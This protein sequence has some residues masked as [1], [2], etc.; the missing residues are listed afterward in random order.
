MIRFR[1]RTDEPRPRRASFHEEFERL[2]K[3]ALALPLAAPLLLFGGW[4]LGQATTD[5]LALPE[6]ARPVRVSASP[7]VELEALRPFMERLRVDGARTVDYVTQYRDHVQPVEKVLRRHGVPASTARRIAWPLVSESSK[8][9]LDPATVVAVVL[10]ESEGKPR[11]TSPVGARGLMQVMPLWAG[12]WR[13]CGG[14]KA[15][16]LYDIDNNLCHGTNILAWYFRT[17]DGDTRRALLGYN[18]CVRGTNTPNCHRY[19]D[20]IYRLSHQIRRELDAERA[21]SVRAAAP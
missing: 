18:G 14:E 13:S 8:R 19:P 4:G 12:K 5:R 9:D 3:R 15:R 21:R 17:Y 16:D 7:R 6:N 2:K 20:K 10:V 11:A 1:R